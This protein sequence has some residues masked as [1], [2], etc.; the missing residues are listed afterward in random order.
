[1]IKRIRFQGVD[2]LA[3]ILAASPDE[4]LNLE[5][6][7]MRVTK[8][9]EYLGQKVES[10]EFFSKRYNWGDVKSAGTLLVAAEE[11]MLIKDGEL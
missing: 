2:Y 11:Q 3:V 10:Q 6:K 9:V 7:D 5:I 1:M 8:E 4:V